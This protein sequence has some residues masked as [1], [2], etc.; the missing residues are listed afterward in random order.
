MAILPT[1][2]LVHGAWHTPANYQSYADAL[3]A[4]GFKVHCPHLPSC[5]GASPPTTSLADDTS[6]VRDIVQSVVDA[7]EHVLMIMHSYGGAVGTGAL[8]GLSLAER[9]ATGQPGGVVHLLY[10]C[11]YILRPGSTVWEIIQ[12]TGYDKLWDQYV[13]TAAD[14]TVAMKDQGLAFFSGN[15]EQTVVDKALKTLV[16][17]PSA[18]FYEKTTGSAWKTIPTTYISTVNDYAVLKPYQDLMLAKVRED[19][20]NAKVEEYDADHSLFITKEAA[21]VEVAV[22]AATDKRNVN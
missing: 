13:D 16:R 4:Q 11:A 18:I 14:G 9:E 2:I 19:G 7:G 20:V 5:N 21:M 12:E 15:A 17:F 6:C 1:V 22:K 10:M 8:E 3:R